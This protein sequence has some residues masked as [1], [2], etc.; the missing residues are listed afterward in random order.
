MS[1]VSGGPQRPTIYNNTTP[2][3]E[4][5]ASRHKIFQ[6]RLKQHKNIIIKIKIYE[7]KWNYLNCCFWRRERCRC[8]CRAPAVWGGIGLT[9]AEALMKWG[10]FIVIFSFACHNFS[11]FFFLFFLYLRVVC[12]HCDAFL[13]WN[14][15]RS[16]KRIL[17]YNILLS[18]CGHCWA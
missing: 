15:S 8:V 10:C 17:Y 1:W 13:L 16:V 7:S 4:N 9:D 14:D 11:V 5:R 2:Y 12:V 3:Y 6:H 18:V